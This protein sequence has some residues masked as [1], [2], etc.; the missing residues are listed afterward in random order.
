[1][2]TCFVKTRRGSWGC[3]ASHANAWRFSRIFSLW[4]SSTKPSRL[5][6]SRNHSAMM[7]GTSPNRQRG[8]STVRVWTLDENL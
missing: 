3:R 4:D 7:P 8:A 1:M 6:Q 5:V 2:A